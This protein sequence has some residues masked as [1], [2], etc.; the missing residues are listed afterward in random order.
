MVQLNLIN[1]IIFPSW[2][3]FISKNPQM[4]LTSTKCDEEISQN[5]HEKK[6]NIFT[7]Q[8]I[9]NTLAFSDQLLLNQLKDN[10]AVILKNEMYENFWNW[11]FQICW[12]IRHKYLNEFDLEALINVNENK[13]FNNANINYNN[14]Y[15]PNIIHLS[16][17]E[18]IALTRNS[19]DNHD[20]M[21]VDDDEQK[22]KDAAILI[23]N[24]HKNLCYELS[25]TEKDSNYDNKKKVFFLWWFISYNLLKI[26]NSK[27]NIYEEEELKKVLGSED[28]HEVCDL[29]MIN[30]ID[31]TH[32]GYD[33][34][35]KDI[36]S[37][38]KHY[39]NSLGNGYSNNVLLFFN[40]KSNYENCQSLF[41]Q[42]KTVN[43]MNCI[44]V[45]F[46]SFTS[47]MEES[48]F[49]KEQKNL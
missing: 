16:I 18:L 1:D 47:K 42:L 41:N 43:N 37:Y 4:I 19:Y 40:E 33:Y 48:S 3:P 21:N 38:G 32:S 14:Y 26:F 35:D 24:L 13:D 39:L 36:L 22:E 27:L 23:L 44:P 10:K 12:F 49:Y 25:N 5:R 2:I 11:T 17:S 9:L 20:R 8:S 31:S 29:S 34:F 46:N 30:F 15:N 6:D 7:V 45:T 28:F